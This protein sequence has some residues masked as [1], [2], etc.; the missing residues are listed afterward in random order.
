[1]GIKVKPLWRGHKA[2]IKQECNMFEP[3][4][5]VALLENLSRTYTV[6]AVHHVL[7]TQIL[8]LVADDGEIIEDWGT[9]YVV[10]GPINS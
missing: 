9:Y 7:G 10:I 2:L 6:S 5:K 8:D 1:M 3:G 4:Q